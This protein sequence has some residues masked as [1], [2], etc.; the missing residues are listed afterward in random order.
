M[1][2]L[3]WDFDGTLAYREG[4]MFGASLIE[5]IE[6]EEP[7]WEGGREA[8]RRYLQTGFPWHT[9]ERP[10]LHIR[11]AADW[12]EMLYPV[13][14]RALE[15]VG[16]DRGRVRA[17]ARQAHAIYVD[18]T[19][20][21]LFPDVVP[22][23]TQLTARGWTHQILSNHVPELPDIV[24]HLGLNAWVSTIHCS[25]QTGY[26]K[27]HPEAFRHVLSALP[28][29]AD[30]WMIGDSVQADVL[31]AEAQGIK[32]VL[33]RK[34]DPRAVRYAEELGGVADLVTRPS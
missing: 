10:H 34:P 32:A 6:H 18:P 26:E 5:V 25:A 33:V 9:P 20:W 24:D 7:D 19:R 1:K 21:R 12:W 29:G 17:M 15:G 31:G 14:E 8:L 28:P 2:T 11:T 13:F 23:L 4:G 22:T 16:F 27:P 30:V 3:I